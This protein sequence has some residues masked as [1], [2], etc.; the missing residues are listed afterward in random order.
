MKTV[1]FT[2]REIRPKDE[3]L[4]TTVTDRINIVE[5]SHSSITIDAETRHTLLQ[6]ALLSGQEFESTFNDFNTFLEDL[7]TRIRNSKP[8]DARLDVLDSLIVDHEVCSYFIY[9]LYLIF[10][11]FNEGHPSAMMVIFKGLPTYI[12][13]ILIKDVYIN[14]YKIMKTLVPQMLKTHN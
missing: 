9:L 6:K 14:T 1:C 12:L 13:T 8:L 3:D 5:Q 2:L 10:Q 7:E 4:V 11:M